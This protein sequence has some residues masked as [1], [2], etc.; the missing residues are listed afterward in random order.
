VVEEIRSG[1]MPLSYYLPMHPAARLT[2]DEK[3]ALIA[4]F[5]RMPGFEEMPD[6][7]DDDDK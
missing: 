4:G 5:K 3:A 7:D 6:N 1:D 2:S